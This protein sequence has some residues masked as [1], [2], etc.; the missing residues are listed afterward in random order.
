MSFRCKFVLFCLMAL[1]SFRSADRLIAAD[2]GFEAVHGLFQKRCI[3]CHG[4]H[5]IIKGE[6]NLTTIKSVTDLT[7][8]TE[9]LATLL[10]VIEDGEMPP[11]DERPLSSENRHSL[12]Q[13]L[14]TMLKDALAKKGFAHAPIRRMNRFQY[15][16]TVMDLF[17]AQRDIFHLPENL[18]RRYSD[19]FHPE[20]GEM[21][22]NLRVA[23]RSLSKDVD[24]SRQ[25]GFMGVASFPQDLRAEH[26]Y[27][28][29]ADHLS[30][31][32][33]L[34]ESFLELSQTIVESK[35]LNPK[36]CR[37]YNRLFSAPDKES[38]EVQVT[39]IRKRLS[40][41]LRRAFRRP[42]GKEEL[43]RFTEFAGRQLKAGT[44]FADAMKTIVGATFASPDFLYLYDSDEGAETSNG[45]RPLSDFELASRLS[46]FFWGSGPDDE[47]LDLAEKGTLRNQTTLGTQITRM[48]NDRRV[49]R[50]CDAFPSQ[51][52]QLDRLISALPDRKAFPHFYYNNSYRVSM[53]MMLEPLLLFET[54]F[55]ENR[56]VVD[57]I[58]PDF[59]W[60]SSAL[61]GAYQGK[62]KGRTV[63]VLTFKRVPVS[64]PR[65]GGII[66]SAAVLTMTSGPKRT[67][68][69]TR[70]AWMNTV[71]FNDPPDPPPAD[72]PPLPE[73]DEAELA[74]LTIR[75]RFEAHRKREDC[76]GCHRQIDPLGFA[77]ENFD[78]TGVW[79]DKYNNGRD[80]NPSGE[81]FGQQFN[82]FLEFREL[83]ARE[84][85]RFVR[86]F[87]GHLLSY[88]LGRELTAA[89]SPTLNAIADNAMKGDD[90]L[91]SLMKQVAMSEPFRHKNT[92]TSPSS[93]AKH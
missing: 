6:V 63:N 79:R 34:M 33:L 80:V 86:A 51:W 90:R 67:L 85:R 78:P 72:V 32:P 53:H 18:M 54:V 10:E 84:Q 75:E 89:D 19:Y 20:T 68:P 65:R 44:S 24:N 1:M 17:G 12:A 55:L 21:P 41:F 15:N 66:P 28:N 76:A 83:L 69:I 25:E 77:L 35:D 48:M 45:T 16:N 38:V 64:D 62:I 82:T 37:N 92:N 58:A 46:Y 9:L 26:G 3:K 31:S 50:F 87:T 11:E 27:D 93:H 5:G 14:K 73:A 57:L 8:R 52:M 42:V 29:R 91:R 56:S 49:V 43:N 81:L 59:S 74:K 4:R 2:A 71:I 36:E 70:G 13:H 22:A 60:V 7:R 30:L 47:L 40:W 61:E 88:G 39:E 23:S